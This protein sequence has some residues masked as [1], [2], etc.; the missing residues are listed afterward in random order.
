M[1]CMSS[2]LYPYACRS[3]TYSCRCFSSSM[4]LR[5]RGWMHKSNQRLWRICTTSL[6]WCLTARFPY[7]RDFSNAQ[8]VRTATFRI[9]RI[10]NTRPILVVV[11]PGSGMHIRSTCQNQAQNKWDHCTYDPVHIEIILRI[12]MHL[13]QMSSMFRYRGAIH[14]WLLVTQSLVSYLQLGKCLL[15]C[16]NSFVNI[17]LFP[18]GL[19][20]IIFDNN[21]IQL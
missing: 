13:F 10:N 11:N 2:K 5:F 21:F 17:L 9:E 18:L 4:S 14:R 6:L 7:T 12:V 19:L 20:I 1:P 16:F 15:R 3:K 8:K